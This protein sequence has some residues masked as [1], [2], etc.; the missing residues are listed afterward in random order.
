MKIVTKDLK[1]LCE[2]ILTDISSEEI[3]I[4]IDFYWKMSFDDYTN[5]TIVD[6]ESNKITHKLL[7]G[8]F[9][10]DWQNLKKI[11]NKEKPATLNDLETLGNVIKISGDS[12]WGHK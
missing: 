5:F 9:V 7:K 3:D 1:A 10:A 4:D 2:K 6:P 8:S 11:I 12:L